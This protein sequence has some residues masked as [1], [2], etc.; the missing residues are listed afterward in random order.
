MNSLTITVLQVVADRPEEKL[1]LISEPASL[2]F[3]SDKRYDVDNS[4]KR[5][6]K[7]FQRKVM[8]ENK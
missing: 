2:R 1:V 5:A 4:V 8:A 3:D 7:T 6:L